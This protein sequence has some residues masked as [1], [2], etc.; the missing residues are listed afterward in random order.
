[1]RTGT[2]LTLTALT[3]LLMQLQGC[4]TIAP[5]AAWELLKVG[6]SAAMAAQPPRPV[7]TIHHGDAPIKE[8]CVEYN[9]ELPLDE[10]V[11]ALQAEL[12]TQGVQS[13]VYD[14]G[15]GPSACEYWLRYVGS[16][17]WGVPPLGEGHRPYL[18]SAALSLH[19]A[20]GRL[21]ASSAYAGQD[22]L[23]RWAT[24]RKKIAPVVKALI[25]GFET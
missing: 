20:D 10:L 1:M 14:V 24:T 13:R 12:K 22:T 23:A 4:S 3:A 6:G 18:S 19:R 17:A 25:T 7:N 15:A 21:L 8:V 2:T 16:I 5:M 11:P 9:R